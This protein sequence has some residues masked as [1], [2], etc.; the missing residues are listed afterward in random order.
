[1]RWSS[2]GQAYR[3]AR[4]TGLDL[5]EAGWR[6]TVENYLGRV[7]KPRILEAVREGAGEGAA[8]LIDHLKK[9][10]MAREAE[11]LLTDTGWLPGPLRAA[12]PEAD[13]DLGTEAVTVALPAVLTEDA[14]GT[15][16]ADGQE[17]DAEA[18][19]RAGEG[20]PQGMAAE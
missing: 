11:R 18:A 14:D 20:D 5:V 6:P 1:M 19:P 12:D 3:L 2:Q 10:D 8:Q 17:A 4:A 13:A 7:T 9:P 15:A 16:G